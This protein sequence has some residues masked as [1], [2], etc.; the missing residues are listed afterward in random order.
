MNVKVNL[1]KGAVLLGAILF[2]FG[3]HPFLQ[4]TRDF[5]RE[6]LSFFDWYGSIIFMVLYAIRPFFF[7]A[8]ILLSLIVGVTFGFMIGTVYTVMGMITGAVISYF[9]EKRRDTQATERGNEVESQI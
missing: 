3:T 6:L 4:L 9:V 8:P 7:R 1:F 5:F 2:L